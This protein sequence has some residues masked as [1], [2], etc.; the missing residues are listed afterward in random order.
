MH[1][2][3]RFGMLLFE[4]ENLFKREL[5]MDVAGTVPEN[6]LASGLRIYVVS[7]IAVRPEDDLLVGG[8][9]IDNIHRVAGSDHDISQSL[10]GSR[11][12][13]VADHGV[14]GMLFDEFF[15]FRSRAAVGERAAGVEIGYQYFFVRAENL[16]SL[17]HEVN[18]THDDDVIVEF[19]G[20]PCESQRVAYE[21]SEVLNFSDS[22][23][24]REDH[25]VLFF[26]ESFYLGY[27]ID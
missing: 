23:I 24:V 9:G 14:A 19:F 6:H 16:D 1:E 2:Y 5:F 25:G 3:F 7:E 11:S 26:L 27:E 10:H 4:F 20:D 22:I 13:D 17:A 18:A 12:V 15:Q 8:E 21:I